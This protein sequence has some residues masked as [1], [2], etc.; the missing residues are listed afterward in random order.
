MYVQN[1][2]LKAMVG[3]IQKNEID[4][5]DADPLFLKESIDKAILSLDPL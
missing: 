1:S 2:F 5:S 3:A 4:K